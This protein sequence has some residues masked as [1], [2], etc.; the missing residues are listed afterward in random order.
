M[1]VLDSRDASTRS[2]QDWFWMSEW[3][4]MEREADEDLDAGRYEDFETMDD[5]I[6]GPPAL[7]MLQSSPSGA[8]Y[9]PT[10]PHRH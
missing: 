1:G 5:F 4:A 9:A 3:Q 8:S 7:L 6:A 10:H 2:D